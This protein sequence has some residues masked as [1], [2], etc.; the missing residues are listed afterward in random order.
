MLE[1]GYDN[2]KGGG[3]AR[4]LSKRDAITYVRKLAR[5]AANYGMSIGLK[6]AQ[7]VLRQLENDVHFAV[8]EECAQMKECGEYK[9]FVSGSGRRVAKPVFHIEYVKVRTIA[10]NTAQGKPNFEI[11]NA[12]WPNATSNQVRKKVC[13]GGET[14]G[15]KLSTVIKE[16]N[17]NGW[18]MYCDGSVTTT[19]TVPGNTGPGPRQGTTGTS[20]SRRIS[21]DHPSAAEYDAPLEPMDWRNDPDILDIITSEENEEGMPES[22]DVWGMDVGPIDEADLDDPPDKPRR[23]AGKDRIGPIGPIGPFEVEDIDARERK[24]RRRDSQQ[25]SKLRGV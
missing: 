14:L 18:V 10:H 23:G 11:A 25:L 17:L 3:F 13:L 2:E 6:N 9:S 24:T 5:E 15:N 4:P 16:F 12:L 1:D 7:G 8:N 22:D 21:A 19:R 20:R